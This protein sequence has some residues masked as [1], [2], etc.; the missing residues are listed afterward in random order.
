[1]FFKFVMSYAAI[2]DFHVARLLRSYGYYCMFMSEKVALET[3]IFIVSMCFFNLRI[4]NAYNNWFSE[5]W[6]SFFVN[7][8]NIE[9]LI[10][11]T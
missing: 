5:S 1:M 6:K 7:S 9:F 2:L 11:S 4:I 10:N 8:K 3:K